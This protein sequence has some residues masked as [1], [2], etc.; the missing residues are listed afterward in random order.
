MGYRT[1]AKAHH[2]LPPRFAR[3]KAMVLKSTLTFDLWLA[4]GKP[5]SPYWKG[6]LF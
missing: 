3:V 4:R 6:V 1:L 2:K 5:I